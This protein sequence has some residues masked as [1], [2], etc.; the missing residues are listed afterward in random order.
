MIHLKLSDTEIFARTLYGEARGETYRFGLNSLKAIAHV[1]CNR[2]RAKT[3]Y[4]QSIK[5]VCLKPLQFSCWNKNDPNFEILSQQ[6]IADLVYKICMHI[7][8]DF[9]KD[10]PD[11]FTHGANHYH[12]INCHPQWAKNK[13][14]VFTIGHHIFYS[15]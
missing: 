15:L 1:I 7:V 14:P 5:D 4:G 13:T 2:V 12:H 10:Q 9:M 8:I 6:Y 3:W 11:D